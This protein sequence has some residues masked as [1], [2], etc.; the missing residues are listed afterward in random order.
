MKGGDFMKKVIVLI[1]SVL[2]VLSVVGF[3]FAAGD[4]TAA[5]AET[6][7]APAKKAPAKVHQVTGEV[8]AVDATAKTLTVKGKK[9]E[10]A[11]S[12]DDKVAAKLADIKVGDK[13]TVKYMEME[14]KKVAIHIVAKKAKMEKPADKMMPAPSPA[15]AK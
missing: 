7:E 6:K 4:T 3:C 10:V 11:L 8:V 12:A 5:P 2:F 13:V 9:E 14:G 1:V 15:P